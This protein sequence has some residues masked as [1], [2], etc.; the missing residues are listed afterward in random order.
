MKFFKLGKVLLLFL[1]LWLASPLPWGVFYLVDLI[2]PTV[3]AQNAVPSKVHAIEFPVNLALAP[4][5]PT[6]QTSC[7]STIT[8]PAGT[9]GIGLCWVASISPQVTG[10]NVYS[11]TTS[12]GPYTKINTSPVTGTTFFF[13]TASLGGVTE[14]FVVRSFDGTAESVNSTETVG[15]TALGNPPPP[16]APQAVRF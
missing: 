12:G 16:T 3:H 10:Y 2:A 14:Y 7:A 9:H 11:S 15:V 6:P 1:I 13:P 8:P 4:P 5:T